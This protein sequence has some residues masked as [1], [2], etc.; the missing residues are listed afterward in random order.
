MELSFLT[1]TPLFQGVQESELKAM[2]PCL[3]AREEMM[4]CQV[5][6]KRIK[7]IAGIFTLEAPCRFF[8]P[9]CLKRDVGCA[10]I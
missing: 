4:A 3:G 1:Q 10:T 6:C 5:S 7:S 9:F 8:P 2:L